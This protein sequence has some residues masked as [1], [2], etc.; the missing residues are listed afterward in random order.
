M[1]LGDHWIGTE[2]FMDEFKT[3]GLDA[4]VGSVGNG[5]TLRLISDIPGVKYT[6]GRFLPYFFPDTFHEGGDPVQGGEGQLGDGAARHPAQAHRPH[7][8]RRLLEAGA[9]SS[10]NSSTTWRACATSSATLYDNV[11]GTTPYCVKTGGGAQLLGQNARLGQPHGAPRAVLQ[12]ELQLCRRH[13][14]A[15]AA[16]PLTCGS[17]ALRTCSADPDAAGRR[18]TC[19][20]NVGD[21]DTAHTGGG[22]WEDPASSRRVRGFVY[23][24]GGF[25]GV[26]EPAG[27]PVPGPL[28]AAGR[29][30]WAWRRRTGFTLNYDKYNWDEHRD[31]FILA[32]CTEPDVDFGEGKKSIFA[33]GRH[34]NSRAA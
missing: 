1:F 22:D 14:G 10:R 8:L 21:G 17:S 28:F 31:H 2:P 11:K 7:R 19:C 34:R 32:D 6:E 12:A 15:F 5:C 24:G 18:S 13:R 30:R 25:I 4:V 26:G 29:R 16:R 23:N 33:L 27:P 3:I 20:I 9:A